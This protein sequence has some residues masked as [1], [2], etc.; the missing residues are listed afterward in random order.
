MP[1]R[2]FFLGGTVAVKK[3]YTVCAITFSLGRVSDVITGFTLARS[4]EEVTAIVRK[5]VAPSKTFSIHMANS[6]GPAKPSIASRE[7]ALFLHYGFDW[8]DPDGPSRLAVDIPTHV[9]RLITE[10]KAL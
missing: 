5:H 7:A 8:L 10:S 2:S 6:G 4:D 3:L 1:L 9:A